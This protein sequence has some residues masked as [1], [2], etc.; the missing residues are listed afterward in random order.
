M[1]L[2][3][4]H[5]DRCAVCSREFPLLAYGN[6]CKAVVRWVSDNHEYRLHLRR[7]SETLWMP[8]RPRSESSQSGG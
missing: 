1:A 6:A 4:G 7:S 3:T 2:W 5:P 8:N